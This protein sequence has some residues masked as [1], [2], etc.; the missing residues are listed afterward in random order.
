[1]RGNL[2]EHC[3][4]GCFLLIL[5]AISCPLTVFSLMLYTVIYKGWAL[6]LFSR[7]SAA[8]GQPKQLQRKAL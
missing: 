2:K 7:Y 3:G 1:M 8:S 6:A 5:S 4:D